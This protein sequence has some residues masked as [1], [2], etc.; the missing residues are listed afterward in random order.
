VWDRQ[1]SCA[2]R[3][4][5]GFNAEACRADRTLARL[6]AGKSRYSAVAG[7]NLNS[8]DNRLVNSITNR[9]GSYRPRRR[10]QRSALVLSIIWSDA[11]GCGEINASACGGQNCISSALIHHLP[12]FATPQDVFDHVTA[13]SRRRR[14]GASSKA[15]FCLTVN[16]CISTAVDHSYRRLLQRSQSRQVACIEI[17][18]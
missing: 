16:Q 12:F 10:F 2:A 13:S 5:R 11:S 6:M 7:I 4:R 8:I 9:C 3:S 17:R 1:R 18:G 15:C 14:E